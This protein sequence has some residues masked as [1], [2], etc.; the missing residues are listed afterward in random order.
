MEIITSETNVRCPECIEPDQRLGVKTFMEYQG[1]DVKFDQGYFE[2]VDGQEYFLLID[3]KT[4]MALLKE[5]EEENTDNLHFL[6][7]E[8]LQSWERKTGQKIII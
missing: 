2:I 6:T 4:K 7:P 3:T 8:L 1:K 5:K